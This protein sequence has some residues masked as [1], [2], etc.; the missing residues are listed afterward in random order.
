VAAS[1]VEAEVAAVGG[2][3]AVAVVAGGAR[4]VAVV[5]GGA[6]LVAEVVGGVVKAVSQDCEITRDRSRREILR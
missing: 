3:Q 1:D 2:A 5:A 6:R 4:V